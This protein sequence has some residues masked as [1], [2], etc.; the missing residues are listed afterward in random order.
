MK[1]NDVLTSLGQK[2]QEAGR[3]VPKKVTMIHYS[4]LKESDDNFYDTTGIE[5]L[6]AAIRLAGE[7]KSPVHVRKTDIDEYEII[8]GHRRRLATIKNVEEHGREDLAFVPCIVEDSDDLLNSINLILS[9]ATQRERTDWEKMTEAAKLREL[10]TRYAKEN[11]T[12]ISS[13]EMRKLISEILGVSGTKVAQLESI[14]KNLCNDAKSKFEKGDLP[15]SVAVELAGLPEKKQKELSTN[16]ELKLSDVKDAKKATEEKKYCEFDTKVQCHIDYV[17]DKYFTK[18]GNIVGCSG[19]CKICKN[20]LTC[21]YSCEQCKKYYTEDDL[22]KIKFSFNDVKIEIMEQK[23]K[24][25]RTAKTEEKEALH[26]KIM[27]EALN[28]LLKDMIIRNEVEA[29]GKQTDV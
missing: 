27:I 22:R 21:R 12:K 15:V 10:L 9:N 3:K 1:M 7:I 13:L 24:L 4:K 8:E 19:C 17:I 26:R 29:D 18:G 25:C 11:E 5:K 28:K 16:P 14:N 2:K 23:R 6:A 20:S